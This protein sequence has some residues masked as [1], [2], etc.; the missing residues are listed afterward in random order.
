MADLK[1]IAKAKELSELVYEITERSPKKFRYTIVGLMQN[2]SLEIVTELYAA[3]DT[4]VS[5]RLAEDLKT[6]IA[7]LGNK[8]EFTDPSVRLYNDAKLT[9]MKIER[10]RILTE[11]AEERVNHSRAAMLK[12][13]EIDWLVSLAAKTQCITRKQQERLARAIYE[14]RVLIGGFIKSDRQRYGV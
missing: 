6:S 14:E 12:L 7:H 13:R 4:Y 3:N 1:V 2:L 5:S 8:T 10:R 9:M 11:R